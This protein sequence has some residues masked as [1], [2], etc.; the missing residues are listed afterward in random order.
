MMP[1]RLHELGISGSRVSLTSSP[2][3]SEQVGW[4]C[5]DMGLGLDDYSIDTD[6]DSEAVVSD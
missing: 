3:L 4:T 5:G 2:T 6:A 1:S